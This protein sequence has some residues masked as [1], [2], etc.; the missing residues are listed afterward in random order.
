MAGLTLPLPIAQD[1]VRP[2]QR[3]RVMT[4]RR[5]TDAWTEAPYLE[6][7]DAT[8]VAGSAVG[9]ASFLWRYGKI[10]REDQTAFAQA[11]PRDLIDQ[12]VKIELLG[13]PGSAEEPGSGGGST[14]TVLWVGVFSDEGREE[15]KPGA[16]GPSG[17]QT[18]KAHG[19]A[20]LLDRGD[21][22]GAYV[23]SSANPGEAE[24]VDVPLI[25]N[26]TQREGLAAE[27]T[28]GN[29]SAAEVTVPGG[30]PAVDGTAFAFSA[31]DGGVWTHGDILDYLLVFYAPGSPA[32]GAVNFT[33]STAV[34]P[35]L[36]Q[37]KQPRVDLSG[38]SLKAAL[39]RLVDPRRGLGWCVR[40]AE[41]VQV[42]VDDQGVAVD[43]NGDGFPDTETVEALE[44]HVFSAFAE[45]VSAAGVTLA[46][47]PDQVEIDLSADGVIA[48]SGMGV[49]DTAVTTRDSLARY[50]RIVVLGN[51]VRSMFTLSPADGTLEAGW[52]LAEETAYKAA[53]DE[54]RKQDKF[55]HVYTRFRAPAAWDWY[56]GNNLGTN[57]THGNANPLCTDAGTLDGTQQGPISDWGHAPERSLLFEKE[58]ADPDAGAT[59]YREPFAII[60]DDGAA[61]FQYLHRIHGG[62]SGDL[63]LSQRELAI[64]VR[65]EPNHFLAKNHW[66]GAVGA[67]PTNA[68]DWTRMAVTLCVQTDQ[69]VRVVE[70]LT[71]TPSDVS[72]SDPGIGRPGR[73]LII[74]VPG[75]E[76][77]WAA[78]GCVR[79][80]DPSTELGYVE[81]LTTPGAVQRDD[82][83][84]L[85][86]VAALAKA[87]YGVDRRAVELI[88]KELTPSYPVG[89][90]VRAVST[91]GTSG[92]SQTVEA[93]VT[94]KRYSFRDRTTTIQ[95]SFAT[96]DFT[97]LVGGR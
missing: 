43:D 82:S 79:E 30:D 42:I 3:V 75:V 69:R 35:I 7:L 66:S 54:E 24:R 16:D 56:T 39:D 12:F 6:P 10:V 72:G 50:D 80:P 53:G 62:G 48:G 96:I 44:V 95:T 21:L 45:P 68:L 15:H 1:A 34:E 97:L 88:L 2:M 9:G 85:R 61:G 37:I 4:R 78:A 86:M 91:G 22:M 84:K 94:S 71:P 74:E 29:R 18:L 31:V 93:V 32:M 14:T 67:L 33:F 36:G 77:W 58:I 47:N 28:A 73:T 81:L 41:R 90:Y 13:A 76:L 17:D 83:D 89:S 25:Y 55:A 26:E 87:W 8:D 19:L 11:E 59:E 20:H 92:Q 46:P 38:L 23:K 51:R 70:S 64:E 40:Y 57:A 65:V 52:T 27:L 49:I 60:Y 63:I 5:W